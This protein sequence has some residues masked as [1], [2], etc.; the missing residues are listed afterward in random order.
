GDAA[1]DE[2]CGDCGEA[3]DDTAKRHLHAA[4]LPFLFSPAVRLAPRGRCAKCATATPADAFSGVK[5]S[6]LDG[7]IRSS[8]KSDGGS[9]FRWFSNRR[10]AASFS[11][12]AKS[13]VF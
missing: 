2:R 3:A 9:N 7:S 13:F 12:F 6:A 1:G 11:Y 10:S 4:F 5:L 8:G